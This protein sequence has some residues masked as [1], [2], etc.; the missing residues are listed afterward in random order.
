VFLPNVLRDL[1]AFRTVIDV[2]GRNCINHHLLFVLP[3][4]AQVVPSPATPSLPL[5]AVRVT[6]L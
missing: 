2:V 1:L 4:S 6:I 3:F 5:L